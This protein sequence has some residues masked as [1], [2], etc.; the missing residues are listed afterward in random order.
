M[1]TPASPS[2]HA[3]ALCTE[4]ALAALRRRFPQIYASQQRLLVEPSQVSV[5]RLDFLAA[6]AGMTPAAHRSATT[7]ARF[8][9]TLLVSTGSCTCRPAHRMQT[10]TALGTS[11][12]LAGLPAAPL[13]LIIH[14]GPG[15]LFRIR[16]CRGRVG[17]RVQTQ[18]GSLASQPV[19]PQAPAGAGAAGAAAC[20][21]RSL[22]AAVWQLPCRR[23]LP[24]RQAGP[25]VR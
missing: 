20:A 21:G 15:G 2:L 16:T 25:S 10:L 11:Q 9:R 24:V 18:P 14:E 3:Q 22:E 5:E 1:Q 8:G 13:W 17:S 23:C 12:L 7:H 4:A 19:C 6:L